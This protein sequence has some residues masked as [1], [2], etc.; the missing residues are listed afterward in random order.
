MKSKKKLLKGSRLYTIIDKESLR[1]KSIFNTV[2]QI[3]DTGADVIQFRDKKSKKEAILK[4]AFLLHKLLLNTKAI[5]I[6][7]DYLDVAKIVDSDGI[8]LGQDDTPIKIAR[9]ILGKDK[10]IGISCHNLK[11]AL[12][13]QKSGADY[14]GI[15]PVF[16]TSTKP[17]NTKIIGLGLIK[18]LKKKLKIPFF[19]IGGIDLNN[20]NRV[21]SAGAER[22][23]VCSAICKAKDI[24][25]TAK[26]FFHLLN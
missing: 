20:V 11:Q 9:Q 2:N 8:H 5:F 12:L 14:I 21:L 22:M 19:V 25:G 23:A 16:P 6:V 26:K 13:A 3:K 17:K 10:I 1:Q 24:S 4:D 7:N 15:G 18:K